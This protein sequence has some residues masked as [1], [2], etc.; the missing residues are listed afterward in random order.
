MKNTNTRTKMV[1]QVVLLAVL[2]SLAGC[3][4]GDEPPTKVC[5]VLLLIPVPCSVGTPS[6]STPTPQAPPP[7]AAP[8]PASPP[9]TDSGGGTN[10]GG[11]TQ[12]AAIQRVYEFEPNNSLDNANIAEFPTAPP[13]SKVGVDIV[14][15]V[16]QTD[17]VADYFIFTPT[18]SKRHSIYVCADT[19]SELVR[20]DMVYVS[21]YDQYQTTINSTPIGTAEEQFLSAELTAGLAYYVEIHGYNT[22]PGA[23]DYRLVIMDMN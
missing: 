10:T 18:R 19:C 21:L 2:A 14:G 8:P 17:D 15:S 9:A 22:G 4:G 23:Y 5:L 13:E 3:G 6:S 7:A 12:T 1:L 16:Q 20:S 11:N